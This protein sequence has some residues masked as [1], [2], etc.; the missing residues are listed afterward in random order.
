LL[1]FQK[2]KIAWDDI[3]QSASVSEVANLKS[4]STDDKAPAS[5]MQISAADKITSSS[6]SSD[7]FTTSDNSKMK[8]VR[9]IRS[10]NTAVSARSFTS[11]E[12]DIVNV[13]S[14]SS[15]LNE[16]ENMS[17]SKKL[18]DEIEDVTSTSNSNEGSVCTSIVN[19]A[20]EVLDDIE[21]NSQVT[22][23]ELIPAAS[24]YD[25]SKDDVQIIGHFAPS[26]S[27]SVSEPA[28]KVPENLSRMEMKAQLEN[29]ENLKRKANLSK[30]PDCGRRLLERIKILQDKMNNLDA[31][32]KKENIVPNEPTEKKEHSIIQKSKGPPTISP[33]AMTGGRRLFGGKMTDNRICLANAVT[34]QVIAQMHSSLANVPENMKTDTPA[35]LLTELMPHQK[36]GLTWLLWREKQSVPGG[37][38]A[39]DMGLGKT[40]SMISLIVNV[41]ERCKRGEVMEEL[42]KRVTKGSRL[43]P[44]RTT[45]IVAPASLIFQWEAEFQKHV[46]SGFLSRYIF[47]GPKQKREISAESLARYDVV[48]TTYGI[49]STELSEKFTAVGIDKIRSSSDASSSDEERN[50]KGKVKRKVSKK[51]G[52]VL[53]K[54]A[55]ERI[56]LDEAH[57][58]KNRTSLISKACC[59]IPAAARWCLTGTPIHNNLWDL[60][61]LIRFLRVVPFNEEA[62]WKEYILSTHSSSQRLNT[63]VKGLLLRREKNQLCTE[64]NKPIVDLKP[65]MY[66]EV[67]MK[68]EGVEKKVYDYIFQVS[69]QQVKELIKT[70]EE[71]ERDLYGIGRT[72]STNKLLKNPFLGGPRTIRSN[73]NFQTMTCV[74]TLLMRLRQACVHLSLIIQAVDMEALQTLGVEEDENAEML[75]KC[76]S[77]ISL[78]DEHAFASELMGDGGN[79]QVEQLFQKTFFSTKC[80]CKPVDQPFEHPGAPSGSEKNS[81]YIYQWKNFKQGPVVLTAILLFQNLKQSR[82]DS[83]NK[84]DSG[85]RVMLL[86]LTAGGVGLNLIGGNHLFLVDLHW[87]PALEQQASDRIYRI[88]QTKNVFIHKLVCLETIEERVLALQQVKQTLAKGVLEGV[89]SKKLSKLTIADLK[90]LFNL[91]R[92]RNDLANFAPTV[93]APKFIPASTVSS[94]NIEPFDAYPTVRKQGE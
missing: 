5:P 61:S 78:L 41:K 62:V 59:K 21:E 56:I 51:S 44:S 45:L 19:S 24:S 73:D 27:T 26:H 75:S 35:S 16:K 93:C 55:W 72:N 50:D 54:I 63:L 31:L 89:A 74:L 82:A 2:R 57:Q 68:L 18:S 23:N 30:L 69:R 53:T 15:F 48:V 25:L 43:I 87:N 80:Y 46:K 58:I 85:P 40:L 67:V 7:I 38:L 76:F 3:G 92:P 79:E 84:I 12:A 33:Q 17:M 20:T 13:S 36:E 22:A 94:T 49:V 65:K 9:E 29:L 11:L 70:R 52:S 91:G 32:E 10:T 81:I 71:K 42:N 83:F 39:D 60:Y 28:Q 90:Y 47:H 64:T 88:G 34:G 37:I 6:T 77:N 8:E 1:F 4:S 86:S 14:S 66:E